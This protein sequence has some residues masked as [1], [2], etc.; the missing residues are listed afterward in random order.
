MVNFLDGEIDVK[1]LEMADV[2]D[3]S[4]LQQFLDNFAVGMNCAAV[5]V[6]R[7]G[8]EVTRPSYYRPFCQDFI[9]KSSIGDSRCATCHNDMGKQAVDLQKPYVGTCHAG[10]IDFAAPVIIKG[11]HIGT[12]LGGQI[13]DREPDEDTIRKVATEIRTDSDALWNAAGK[14][15]II[16]ERNIKAAAEVLFEVVN[17]LAQNGYSRLETELLANNL[18]ESFNQISETIDMLANSAQTITYS[19]EGLSTEIQQIEETA[20][21]ISDIVSSISKVADRTKMIGLNASIEAARLGNEG[22][23]FSVVAKEIRDLAENTKLTAAQITDLNLQI[24]N[25]V[26]S[27]I[28]QSKTTLETTQDQSAAMEELSATV[29]EMLS[30]VSK[31]QKLFNDED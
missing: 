11:E 19:Q 13:L 21:K 27:T 5:S 20:N 30:I 14:I 4:M 7:E 15:D 10:L 3:I 12:V 2:I 31:L 6:D 1:A 25:K 17:A 28:D 29:Q 8:H 23:S 9:H 16:P 24:N 18:I 26:D 22:R